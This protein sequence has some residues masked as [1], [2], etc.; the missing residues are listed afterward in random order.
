MV[1]ANRSFEMMF[2]EII[3]DASRS[4][5]SCVR[6]LRLRLPTDHTYSTVL[7]TWRR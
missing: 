5:Y 2:N 1:N 4:W 7:W 3:E 6:T